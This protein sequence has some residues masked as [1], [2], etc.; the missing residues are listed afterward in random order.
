MRV[1]VMTAFALLLF[2]TLRLPNLAPIRA[3][4]ILSVEYR[5]LFIL[6]RS[7][8]ANVIHYDAKLRDGVVDPDQPVVAYWILKATDGRREELSTA[9]KRLAYG[10][11]IE[12]ARSGGSFRLVLVAQKQREIKIYQENEVVRAETT[13]GG[14]RAILQRLFVATKRVL[15]VP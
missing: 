3:L 13:I 15:W 5:T 7:T 4:E 9:E 11:S 8:N 1:V 10:F 2:L 14:H 6:E 12:R